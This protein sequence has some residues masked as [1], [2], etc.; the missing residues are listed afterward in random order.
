MS[1]CAAVIMFDKNTS[2]GEMDHTAINGVIYNT[3]SKKDIA[4]Y[5]HTSPSDGRTSS[6][7]SKVNAYTAVY[8]LVILFSWG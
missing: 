4:Y 5:A 3:N 2:D 7:K 6:L 1:K 8:V